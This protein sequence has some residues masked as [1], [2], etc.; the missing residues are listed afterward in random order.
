MR[1]AGIGIR[2][3]SGW[4]A[5][6]AVTGDAATLQVVERRRVDIIEPHV[7]GAFQP[8]HFSEKLPLAKAEQHLAKCAANSSQLAKA[9]MTSV[10]EE[11]RGQGYAVAGAA[12]LMSSGR[13]LP[14][15]AGI[16]A[17]HALIHTAEGEFFRKMFREGLEAAGISVVGIK[18]R[19]LAE[20]A[21]AAFGRS[22]A[23]LQKKI[24]GFGKTLG[25]PWTSDQKLATMAAC[26]V[27]RSG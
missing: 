10:M 21:Q 6:V 25:A 24:D 1:S 16:L 27:M 3:H 13:P 9:A 4:G 12:I 19:E 5:L 15:L 17:S 8:Y 22:A 23:G 7:P 18:E 11:L 20:R 14:E 26:V 2:V